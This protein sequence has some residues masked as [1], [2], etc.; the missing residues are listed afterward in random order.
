MKMNILLTFNAGYIQQTIVMLKSLLHA[1]P[2]DSF[3]VYVMNTELSKD[4]FTE[5]EQAIT[6]LNY[7]NRLRI[8]DVKI[9]VDTLKDAPIT[10]R[11]PKEMYFRIFAAHFLPK[12]LDR[13][14]YL[15]PDLVI[16][17]SIKGLYNMNLEDHFF[18]AASHVRKSLETINALRLRMEEPG[19]YINSG[20]MLINLCAL[21]EEQRLESVYQY[22]AKHKNVLI[23]P[24][25][26]VISALYGQR[27]RLVDPFVYN[28]TER[29]LIF[30]K[31]R[32]PW[33][34]LSWIRKNS[35]IIH[36]CGRNKP[37]NERYFGKL[38]LF[39]KRAERL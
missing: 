19:P 37:W 11:Y 4:H 35:V 21:R 13:V 15:D 32:Y 8:F 25:Q 12:D 38:D 29:Q 20:V 6:H 27:I 33:L 31:V 18:I 28:M 3:D 14:L 22:I 5:I 34:N 26:D 17:N 1:N 24:D 23:L 39:Y 9:N 36:Y 2:K 7:G 30:N 10:K 16:I